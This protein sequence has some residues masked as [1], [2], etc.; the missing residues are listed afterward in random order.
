MRFW[1][2]LKRLLIALFGSF[3]WQPPSWLERLWQRALAPV[4]Q[5]LKLLREPRH[6]AKAAIVIAVLVAGV[7]A[8]LF[9]PRP[10]A[11]VKLTVAVSAPSPPPPHKASDPEPTPD[12]V[13]VTFDG[14][15][16]PLEAI[17]H[18]IDK[19]VRLT[20]AHPGSWRWDGDNALV[21]TPQAHWPVGQ[22]FV[23]HIDKSAVAGHVVL[24]DYAPTFSTAAF[25]ATL[26]DTE[27]YQDPTDPKVKQVVAT[28][29][30]NYPVDPSSLKDRLSMQ[31]V[32]PEAGASRPWPF[33]VTYDDLKF[34]AYLHSDN[35]AIP[36]EDQRMH[37]T[38]DSGVHAQAGGPATTDMSERDVHIPGRYNLFKIR[39]AQL[40][41]VR[42]ETYDPE[43]VLVV[44][45]TSGVLEA[46][47][48]GAI[49]AWV[50]PKDKPKGPGQ[51]AQKDYYWSDPEEIGPEVLK[52]S[53]RVPLAPIP[54]EHEYSTQHTFK[55][56]A[57][58]S[59]FLYV[60]IKKGVEAYGGYVLA[61]AWDAVVQVPE[62]PKEVRIMHEG[63]VLS[64][65][66]ERRLNVMARGIAA[67]RIELWRILPRELNH[68]LSQ[69]SGDFKSPYFRNYNFNE[70][71]IA[72]VFRE[73]RKLDASD[74][75]RAQF[76]AVDFG[77]YID[78]GSG[79]NRGLFV[80]KVQAWDPE[81]NK[82]AD[83]SPTA[84][85]ETYRP[86]QRS[87]DEDYE[88]DD[89]ED[90]GDDSEQEGH[91]QDEGYAEEYDED[92]DYGSRSFDQA[93]DRRFILL[94]DLG[95]LVKTDASDN[96]EVFVQ[97]ITT[98]EPVAGATVHVLGKNGVPVLSRSTS[99]QGE[100]T[101]PTLRDFTQ[102]KQP[103]AYVVR[104]GADLSFLPMQRNDRLLNTSRF[105][106]GGVRTRGKSGALAAYLFSDR[107]IYRP[108]DSFHVAMIVKAVDWTRGLAGVPVQL[109][110]RDARGIEVKKERRALPASGFVELTYETEE[111][112]PTGTW[113]ISAYIV[114]DERRSSLLGSTTVR[115][116]EFLPDRL[117]IKSYFD[118]TPGEGWIKPEALSAHVELFNLFGTPAVSHRISASMN[119][120][121]RFVAFRRWSQYHFYD[122]LRAEHS[123]NERLDDCDTDD[124]GVCRFSL[125]LSRFARATYQVSL[126]AEGYELDGGRGVSTEAS[127][128]VS[129]LEH[130]VGYRPDG[131]LSYIKKNAGA[132]VQ[133]I[134]VDPKLDSI[135][136][137]DL[138]A[139]RIE[140]RWV[141]V[142]VRQPNGTFKYQ[143][144]QKD[145][146]LGKKKLSVAKG[147]S[148]LQLDTSTPGD[149]VLSIRDASDTELNRISYSV[150]GAASLT[151]ELERNAELQVQLDKRDYTPGDTIEVSI[152]AP[153]T[154]AGL[155]TIERDQVYAFKWFK[156]DTTASVQHITLP[157]GLEGNGYVSVAF[158]RSLD[159]P[160]IFMSP[161]SH[162]VVPFSVSRA[163]R[164]IDIDLDTP[165][166]VRPGD[167]V[168]IGYK[169]NRPAKI[170]IFGVDEGILQ[171]A[172][173]TTPDPLSFFFAKRALEVS[174]RQIL[175][176]IL[177]EYS[178]AQAASQQGGDE[179][180]AMLAKN[181]NPFKRKR[182]A[183]V[184]FWS[185]IV[186]AGVDKRE[187]S[188]TVPDYFNGTLRV[189]AV[190]VAQTAIGAE[191]KKSV[192]RGPFVLSPNTPLFVA[193]G[194][195]FEASVAVA[196][197]VEGSGPK[198][199]VKVS[200]STD[201]A[202]KIIGDNVQEV[203]IAEGTE[204][205]VR[206]RVQAKSELGASEL[207]F[208]AGIGEV[209]SKLAT[210]LSVRPPTPYVT[211]VKSGQ[212][213]D[214]DADVATP[215]RVYPHLAK[216]QVAVSPLPLGLA[217]GLVNY[218]ENYPYLCTEQLVSATVP[219]L[220]LR[221]YPAFGYD[222]R[223]S[224]KM[225][226]RTLTILQGRQNAEG[227][228]GFWAANSHAS[229]FQVVY[230]T[231][232]L[233]EAA[234]RGFD[235]PGEMHN[236]ALQYVR[237]LAA[238]PL[239][240]L[241]D[242]R[243]RA[244]AIY[245]LAL[246][247]QLATRELAELRQYLTRKY[248][249]LWPKDV[250]AAYMAGAY[251]LMRDDDEARRVLGKLELAD[252]V[253]RDETTFYDAQSYL[254]QVL[255]VMAKHFPEHLDEVEA[256]VLSRLAESVSG[257]SY[258]SLSSAQ[259]LWAL[260]TYAK[261]VAGAHKP[262]LGD[263]TVA[264][265]VGD[266]NEVHPLALSSGL[267]AV[268]SFSREAKSVRID[269]NSD[270][271]VF[272][273]VTVSAFDR[274]PPKQKVAEGLEIIHVYED[275]GGNAVSSAALGD[276]VRVRLKLRSLEREQVSNVAVVDL[277]PAGFDVVLGRGNQRGI[278]GRIATD[279]STWRP[280]YADVREDRVIFYGTVGKNVRDL[281]YEIKAT[282]RG[283]FSVPPSFVE[284]MYD[285]SLVARSLGGTLKVEGD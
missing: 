157:A 169:T 126:L 281:V 247:G 149:F 212:L 56:D 228:F 188:Y 44:D 160:E 240:G 239:K 33:S 272:Y 276:T 183:P 238:A 201:P 66:G 185:G 195:S 225:M 74:A 246:N 65:S 151:R 87:Q 187:I 72:E 96:H 113:S 22:Q 104:R 141:S 143:S 271:P 220:V 166:L 57:P 55:L 133:L 285:R 25:A 168:A 8:Y 189:M 20:P 17:D 236:R 252:E 270:L 210:S 231:H 105:D 83:I 124:A 1:G 132:S 6:L 10:P 218:L 64:V 16:A 269:S 13:R 131:D 161:L 40:T 156:T 154:G 263:V 200:L 103:V 14:S 227:A 153:Y 172:A 206:F 102:E 177:P 197:N 135:A 258:N 171:V 215:R 98:G 214:E 211:T 45:C 142:L 85:Y 82:P 62:Y 39:R 81:K 109:V 251:H 277:L 89:D 167:K 50:L 7:L 53:R 284:A 84:S 139:V 262:V 121:P 242:A 58:P 26:T 233:T 179:E 128:L 80:L 100:A 267:V 49:Q 31:L 43:Q 90:Y 165:S 222:K 283:S 182:D 76:T 152:K 275:A 46:K 69:S 67:V 176:L 164:A 213:K 78:A 264:E 125:D 202:L 73:V 12:P 199:K 148:R 204:G 118:S 35:L 193:P 250:T 280:D 180:A 198:A 255:L 208:V 191:Q 115:I 112:A 71:N 9:W 134:A 54:A 41:L 123:Y 129:P 162:G 224:R 70:Q 38:L 249:K 268:A 48:D 68:L 192:V 265:V 159:S 137:A 181:L 117:R 155:L 207:R 266:K 24:A 122:P 219:A 3:S 196:N 209:K 279:A 5:E 36:G 95:V 27:F 237:G 150:A 108:G 221:D 248:P 47:L 30:F 28:V 106:V 232:F 274:E 158:V 260:A 119:L 147:G 217:H 127:V 174:T 144:V 21:F 94:T 61:H 59:R 259:S 163:Q 229:D 2:A 86:P 75:R 253:K 257:G 114:K 120:S 245:V 194:D 77:P 243:L 130:L 223:R 203:A 79:A 60:R 52:K 205:A 138:S 11:P 92:D 244:Y 37:I 173:Y 29:R 136:L 15:A 273:A 111:S 235:V 101:F 190:A 184:V 97:S 146:T 282:A 107:G 99:A 261:V 256:P 88:G 241:A 91:E 226:E 18:A 178:V 254:A 110:V 32:D 175:D 216:L 4:W 51:K 234:E 170:V 63:A 145:V 116:E 93:E 140:R 278:V 186:D 34:E 42:N 23:V 19:G 230:A